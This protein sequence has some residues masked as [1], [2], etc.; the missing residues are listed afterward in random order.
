V[1]DITISDAKTEKEDK[2]FEQ[3]IDSNSHRFPAGYIDSRLL[4]ENRKEAFHTQT[5][6]K[7]FLEQIDQRT[8]LNG[9]L[10]LS[11]LSR[12]GRRN[13][14]D[15]GVKRRCLALNNLPSPFSGFR[16]LHVSD[17]H[18]NGDKLATNNLF[19]AIASV[20]YDLCV[21]TGDYRYRSFGEI[22]T[23]LDGVRDIRDVVTSDVIAVLGNHDSLHMVP[24]MESMGIE[25]LLNEQRTVA[26][27]DAR[28][29]IIGVD[30][31]AYYRTHDLKRAVDNLK[32]ESQVC[33][34]LLA[35]SPDLY[36]QASQFGINAYL[37]GHTHGGQICLPGGI[38]IKYNM[39]APR[40]MAAGA[41]DYQ[42]MNGYTSVGAGTS[43]VEARFFCRPEIT[44]HELVGAN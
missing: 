5:S 42:G 38:P 43:I 36:L 6:T 2:L 18:F 21:L 13:A 25:V 40:R 34:I 16:I 29:C 30:D 7:H 22:S 17:P 28:I 10:K 4:R 27:N 35:H 44:V 41:W 37:C 20:D 31:P 8:I 12:I 11:G 32:V 15:I 1:T 3:W 24:Q 23:A 33:S 19:N 26:L 14:A 9:V 39:N